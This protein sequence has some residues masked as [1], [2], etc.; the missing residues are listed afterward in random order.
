[1]PTPDS[2]IALVLFARSAQ[3][4]ACHK[5]L[6]PRFAVSRQRQVFEAFNRHSLAL[7]A[8]TGLPFFLVSSE[9]QQGST[10][11]ERLHQ[12]LASTFARGF[13]NVIVIGNDCPQLKV[14]DLLHAAA[15][16]QQQGAVLGPCSQGGVYLLGLSKALFDQVGTFPQVAWHTPLVAQQLKA[17]LQGED[18]G[19]ACLA[20]Y[21][22]INTAGDF[23]LARR[24][25]WFSRSLR[26]WLS[27]LLDLPV[28]AIPPQP[29]VAIPIHTHPAALFRGPPLYSLQ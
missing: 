8:A 4:E 12:A 20:T 16:L 15:L 14:S 27:R 21:H 28:P 9:Q 23:R 22:D 2:H 25:Q 5:N 19:P 10:F 1:M 11:G 3:E 13:E 18:A 17:L 29:F 7:L 24:Q 26:T 6:L